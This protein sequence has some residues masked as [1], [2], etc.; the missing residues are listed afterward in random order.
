VEVLDELMDENWKVGI[1]IKTPNG[2][3]AAGFLLHDNGPEIVSDF[4]IIGASVTRTLMAEVLGCKFNSP[5]ED[6]KIIEGFKR[7]HIIMPN[8][9][10]YVGRQKETQGSDAE[11]LGR[12][13]TNVDQ[14]E[15]AG[16]KD[17]G[18]EEGNRIIVGG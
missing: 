11:I 1:Y 9:G 13:S 16:S 3:F 14:P 10:E 2:E 15:E 6:A 18:K 12:S 5:E 8:G 4:N 7:S 17:E